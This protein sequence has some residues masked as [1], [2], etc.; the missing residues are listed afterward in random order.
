MPYIDDPKTDVTMSDY[1][2]NGAKQI[3]VSYEVSIINSTNNVDF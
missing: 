2:N 1:G 3:K